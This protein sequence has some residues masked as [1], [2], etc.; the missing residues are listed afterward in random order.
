MTLTIINAVLHYYTT[1]NFPFDQFRAQSKNSIRNTLSQWFTATAGLIEV[2]NDSVL[3]IDEFYTVPGL[4]VAS[5][6]GIGVTQPIMDSFTTL[7]KRLL[8]SLRFKPSRSRSGVTVLAIFTP[9]FLDGSKS[10]SSSVSTNATAGNGING[11]FS[12]DCPHK[13]KFCPRETIPV[14]VLKELHPDIEENAIE[15][16]PASMFITKN[17]VRHIVLPKSYSISEPGC[18]RAVQYGFDPELQVFNRLKTYMINGH[19]ISKLEVLLL[20]GTFSSYPREFIREFITRMYYAVN[21]IV[22]RVNGTPYREML[23][24]EEELQFQT[25]PDYTRYPA[26]VIGLT[27]ETR[28]DCLVKKR[29]VNG[30]LQYRPNFNEVTF[31]RKLGVTRVQLGVQHLDNKI[32]RKMARGCTYEDSVAAF[33]TLKYCGFKYDI[34]LMP[35]CPGS[36]LE[37]D[38]DM[39]TRVF[40]DGDLLPDQIKLYP[41]YVMNDTPFAEEYLNGDWTLYTEDNPEQLVD[42]LAYALT[43]ARKSIRINRV[44]RDLPHI[45]GNGIA[46]VG[47]FYINDTSYHMPKSVSLRSI[48]SICDHLNRIMED[49]VIKFDYNISRFTITTKANGD[50]SAEQVF[51]PDPITLPSDAVNQYMGFLTAKTGKTVIADKMADIFRSGFISHTIQHCNL[52]NS[53]TNAI[54]ASGLFESDIRAREPRGLHDIDYSQCYIDVETFSSHGGTEY[55]I[56]YNYPRDRTR[57]MGHDYIL[58]FIRLRI[59][60]KFSNAMKRELREAGLDEF[61]THRAMI[62]ELHVYGTVSSLS[63]RDGHSAESIQGRGIGKKLVQLAFDI[64]RENHFVNKITVIPG[65]GVSNYYRKFNFKPIGECNYYA[66][67]LWPFTIRQMISALI[68]FLYLIVMITVIVTYRTMPVTTTGIDLDYQF[69]TLLSM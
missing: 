68:Y 54:R 46:K 6:T 45:T 28:P 15:R 44:G 47:R 14:N 66:V 27:I 18:R 40:A 17:G 64:A 43:R 63:N 34:H 8:A 56:S 2:D 69:T 53:I 36:T 50:G 20:G 12:F 62:R 51:I 65:V 9:A 58:G 10:S 16:A 49:A 21:T 38:L 1:G 25:H 13:C 30:K 29:V 67:T 5:T 39:F 32:L 11:N 48:N 41:F 42:V 57:S 3:T 61:T 23:S 31:L 7:R 55:F 4:T 24:L 19:D 60:P 59:N 22:D 33:K 52:R 37:K 35:G 26:R